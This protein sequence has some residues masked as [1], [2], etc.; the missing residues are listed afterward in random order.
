VPRASQEKELKVMM[1]S[2]LARR[3]A[4]HL[5]AA[6]ATGA[7]PSVVVGLDGFV[8]EI[9]RVVNKRFSATECTLLERISDL[10]ARISA[11]SGQSTNMELIVTQVK[12]GGNGPIMANAMVGLGGDVTC[13]GPMGDTNIHFA[14]D[15][16]ANQARVISLG[17]PGHTDALEFEDGKLMFGKLQ[18]LNDITWARINERVGVE[19]TKQ[20]FTQSNLIALVNWT[21]I[22]AMDDIWQS[23]LDLLSTSR[24]KGETLFFFDLA[25]PEKHDDHSVKFACDLLAKFQKFAPTVLGLNEKEAV[26]VAEVYGYRG[27]THGRDS[28]RTIAN[29]VSANVPVSSVAVHPREWALSSSQ[30]VVTG[31]TDGPFTETPKIS[32]GAGDHFNAGFCRGKLAGLPDDECLAIGVGTSGYYVRNAETPDIEKLAAFIEKH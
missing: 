19:Q 20:L 13:I 3:T 17:D 27:S 16:L 18:T 32:T 11:A 24:P 12:I 14:F 29:Y 2:D 30:G 28:V 23:L 5:R 4:A 8:D 6:G 7:K 21:M 22:P 9:I 15:G 26:R 10:A 1:D 31:E 25:D